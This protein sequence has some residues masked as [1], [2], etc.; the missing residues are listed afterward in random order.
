MKATVKHG[1]DID[2]EFSEK[3][4]LARRALH[5][6]HA[7]CFWYLREDMELKP[8]DL[9]E[10]IRGLRHNGGRRGFLLAERLCR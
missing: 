5:D 8:S 2:P 7:Q 4:E 9:E 3:M 6:F 1:N 10:I